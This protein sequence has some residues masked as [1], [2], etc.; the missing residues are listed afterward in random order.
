MNLVG[1]ITKTIHIVE[2]LLATESIDIY[3]TVLFAFWRDKN[4]FGLALFSIATCNVRVCLQLNV[5]A[6]EKG[7]LKCFGRYACV[8]PG[9]SELQT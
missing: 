7:M 5:Y 8:T 2:I 6:K 4:D 3:H 1:P 9:Y